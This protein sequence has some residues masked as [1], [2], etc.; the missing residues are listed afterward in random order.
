MFH[1]LEV[2]AMIKLDHQNQG[3]GHGISGIDDL[4]SAYSTLANVGDRLIMATGEYADT[5]LELVN[6]KGDLKLAQNDLQR[7]KSSVHAIKKAKEKTS[8]VAE[9]F[10]G[11]ILDIKDEYE[12]QSK[13]LITNYQNATSQ[14]KQDIKNQIYGRFQA[15]NSTLALLRNNYFSE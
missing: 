15:M 13:Q 9:N 10:N 8:E 11:K 6:K 14:R 4:M 12:D 5:T 7:A 1:D 2:T 3:T